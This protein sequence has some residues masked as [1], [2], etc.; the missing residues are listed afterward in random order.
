M[1]LLHLPVRFPPLTDLCLGAALVCGVC[2]AKR[3]LEN[4]WAPPGSRASSISSLICVVRRSTCLHLRAE[5]IALAVLERLC[6]SRVCWRAGEQCSDR[7]P[8]RATLRARCACSPFDS[9]PLHLLAIVIIL[10]LRILRCSCLGTLPFTSTH[11]H[12]L[13]QPYS[14]IRRLVR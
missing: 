6:V 13:H 3:D 12:A 5:P 7:F 8:V 10:L 9:S 1:L 14:H 4:R 2:C 11:T